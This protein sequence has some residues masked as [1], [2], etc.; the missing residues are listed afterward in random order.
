MPDPRRLALLLLLATPA[1]AQDDN[2]SDLLAPP[3]KP[4]PSVQQPSYT[5]PGTGI[6]LRLQ[7]PDQPNDRAT[8]TPRLG[9]SAPGLQLNL[10]SE[11][12]GD[13]LE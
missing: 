7:P 11:I 3:P 1:L 4:P 6:D 12:F 13:P 9:S 10:P 5:L 8:I 2:A